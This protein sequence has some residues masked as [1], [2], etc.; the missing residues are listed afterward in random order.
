MNAKNSTLKFMFAVAFLVAASWGVKAQDMGTGT[1]WDNL[2]PSSPL[3]LDEKFTDFEFYHNAPHTNASNSK[4]VVDETTGETTP[5]NIGGEKSVN[6]L[7]SNDQVT[8]TWDSCAFAPEW[9]V[10][11]SLTGDGEV[12]DPDPTTPNVSNGFVEIARRGYGTLAGEFIVDLRQLSY[13]E[14]IQYTHSS[15]GGKRRGFMILFSLDDG[16]SWDTLRYQ[17]GDHY[18]LNFTKDPF[19]LSKTPNDINCTPSANGMLW[20]DGIYAEN[21][22][23][24]FSAAND[25]EPQAVRIHDLKVYGD[26]KV[27]SESMK[28]NK[29]ELKYFNKAIR[30]NTT[31]D[32]AVY[33]I[34]GTL[35]KSASQVNQL[36]THDLANGMYVVKA[37]AGQKVTAQKIVI[38]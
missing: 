22:M 10:A 25:V 14:G 34:T 30:V 16:A 38:R 37:R 15:C 12:V 28:L 6:F 7:N 13:V 21:V 33:S 2:N 8:Y 17:L 23:L 5:A 31:A 36:S 11:A 18:S 9:G 4:D 29:L 35:I 19:S 26:L 20:E 27:S 32:L 24:K 3:V 1:G